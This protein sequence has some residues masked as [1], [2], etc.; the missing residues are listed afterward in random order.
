VIQH[1][2]T[3]NRYDPSRQ[4]VEDNSPGQINGQACR[5][6]AVRWLIAPFVGISITHASSA[7][8]KRNIL[9]GRMLDET[10]MGETVIATHTQP[11]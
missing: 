4:R 9:K 6:Q 11:T 7:Q 10:Q 8:Y 3:A 1:D 2:F 5:E